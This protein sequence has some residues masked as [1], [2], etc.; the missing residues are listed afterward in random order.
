MDIKIA[1]AMP[2]NRGVK[3]QTVK[4][5]LELDCKYEKHIIIATQGYTISENRIY[6]AMQAIK[7][8]CTH[9]L[10]TD[11]DMIFPISTLNQLLKHNK[12]IVGVVANSRAFPLMPVVEFFDDDKISVTDRL[13]GRRDIPKELF[14]CKAVGGGVTLVK[15]NIYDK[16]KKPWYDTETYDFGMTK[17]GEDSWF[18]R[19]I[20]NEGIKIWCDPQIKIGHIGSYVF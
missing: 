15:T 4:S 11:D 16:I 9:I 19:Q 13:M 20:R 18:C 17:M 12:D 3:A 10:S 1:I 6:I 2:T 5:L 8:K 14:E 7:N